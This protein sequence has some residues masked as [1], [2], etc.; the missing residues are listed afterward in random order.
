MNK[1]ALSLLAGV[2][3]FLLIGC[4]P[5]TNIDALK[6]IKTICIPI[7]TVNLRANSIYLRSG[8]EFSWNLDPNVGLENKMI[9]IER[10]FLDQEFTSTEKVFSQL[11]INIKKSLKPSDIP[12]IND[13]HTYVSAKAINIDAGNP[14]YIKKLCA[15]AKT[16]ALGS[17][18][19]EFC[20]IFYVEPFVGSFIKIQSKAIIKIYSA[21]GEQ[22]LSREITSESTKKLPQDFKV[23]LSLPLLGTSGLTYKQTLDFQN[24]SELQEYLLKSFNLRNNYGPLYEES[25]NNLILNIQKELDTVIQEYQK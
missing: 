19:L 10:E 5:T 22:I 9:S 4:G 12:N 24:N 2:S 25:M 3:I 11:N 21:S 14:D 23:T 7:K 15:T 17:I 16:D 18:N 6:K 1:N 8:S 13:E 20:K